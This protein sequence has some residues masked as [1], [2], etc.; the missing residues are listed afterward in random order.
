M[1]II[2]I[3]TSTIPSRTANSIQVMQMC[4]AFTQRGA[5]LELVAAWQPHKIVT[6]PK[7]FLNIHQYY[8]L[9]TSFPIRFL[10]NPVPPMPQSAVGKFREKIFL[11]SAARYALRN[12]PTLVY[13]RNLRLAAELAH[14]DVPV[15]VECHEYE[16]FRDGGEL[17][18]LRGAANKEGLR[19]IVVISERL[20]QLYV[21]CGL[22]ESKIL[23]AH[24][25]VDDALLKED[26]APIRKEKL[27]IAEH[28]PVVCYT[29]KM[30]ADRGISLLLD[31]A[32]ALPEICFVLVGG[33][34][35]E[36]NAWK[37]HTVGIKNVVFTGFVSPKNVAQYLKMADVLVAPYTTQI[38]TLNAASPLK[39]FEYMAMGKPAVISRLPTIQEVVQDGYNGILIEPDSPEALVDGLRRAFK[40]ESRQIGINARMSVQEYTWQARAQCIL[41]A[42]LGE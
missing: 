21:D 4:Q 32:K 27:G 8:G 13:T 20:K 7:A 3:T 12:Q 18:V 25:G 37:R 26:V 17:D 38:P 5:H 15:A 14:R 41:D 40:P 11:R 23:V 1:K 33:T 34:G 19:L 39:V 35:K 31:A 10:F 36:V 29:G 22:P 2:Y 28:T 9:K 6:Q 42:L 24:D 30:S 16:L